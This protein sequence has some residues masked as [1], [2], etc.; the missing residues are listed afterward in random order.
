MLQFQHWLCS[1]KKLGG[2]KCDAQSAS[3]ESFYVAVQV[4]VG[5]NRPHL[6]VASVGQMLVGER[7]GK[8][9]ES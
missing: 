5:P 4:A 8:M 1:H 3:G 9:R 7:R 2:G 6:L